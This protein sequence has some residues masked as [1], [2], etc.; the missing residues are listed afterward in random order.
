MQRRRFLSLASAAPAICRAGSQA[1]STLS[2]ESSDKR[3]VDGF[4]W[5]KKQALAFAFQGDPVGP[6]YEAALPGREAFCM[7]DVAHQCTGGHALGLVRHNLNMLYRFAENISDSK[8]WC[9]YW[10]I[11]RYNRPA[12]VDYKNDAEFWYN[13]PANFDVLDACYRMYLWSGNLRY[14]NDSV[15]LNFYDRTVADYVARWELQLD[16]VMKRKRF[17]NIRSE[18]DPNKKFHFYRGDPSYAEN[19]DQ[20]VLGVDLLASQYAAYLAYANIRE[21]RGNAEVSR[22]YR[23]KALDVKLLINSTWWNE[24]GKHFYQRLSKDYKLEGRGSSNLL[25]HDA[26]DDGPKAQSALQ[27]L[28]TLIKERPSGSVE[29]QSH[30]AEIL[31]RYGVPD[32]AYAQM[33]DLT[34]EDRERREYPEVPFSIVG[35]VVTGTMGISVDPQSPLKAADEPQFVDRVVKTLPALGEISWAQLGNLFIRANEISV[36]H[37]SGRTTTFTNQRGPSLIWHASFDGAHEALLVNGKAMKAR[38]E[39]RFLGRTASFARIVVGPGNTVRA[40]VSD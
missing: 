35:A 6:W 18:F 17:I 9:S 2:L 38:P 5:A 33:M 34:R 26:A 8:D 32:M 19:R 10:E 4:N 7:R 3:L 39:Q 23:K 27:A 16:R 28:L 30:H 40:Q 14:V 22:E 29:G 12:P 11:D 21:V 20:F 1:E 15:F 31:Y 25:Y 37:E 36:R 24:T 13:L